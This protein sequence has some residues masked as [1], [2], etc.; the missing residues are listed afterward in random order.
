MLRYPS[1]REKTPNPTGCTD[2]GAFHLRAQFCFLREVSNSFCWN[3]L[4]TVSPNLCSEPLEREQARLLKYFDNIT[5]QDG[6]RERKGAKC[7]SLSD[8]GHNTITKQLCTSVNQQAL[9]TVSACTSTFLWGGIAKTT[10][11]G[12]LPSHSNV[13]KETYCL[14]ISPRHLHGHALS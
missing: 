2:F 1:D 6:K 11:A 8:T 3:R 4:P 5:Q 14:Q 10:P 13:I 7:S 9:S 12:L